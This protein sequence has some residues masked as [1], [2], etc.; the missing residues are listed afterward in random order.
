L[1]SVLRWPSRGARAARG[2]P[3]FHDPQLPPEGKKCHN[4]PPGDRWN[5]DSKNPGI[6]QKATPKGGF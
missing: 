4:A 3:G 1:I 2:K 5:N 6:K